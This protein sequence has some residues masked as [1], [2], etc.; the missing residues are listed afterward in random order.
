VSIYQRP[1]DIQREGPALVL[2]GKQGAAAGSIE[3][4]SP[5]NYLAVRLKAGERWRYQ[6]P[7]GHTVLWTAVASGTVS[8]PNEL[9][10]GDMA[11]FF[12]QHELARAFVGLETGVGVDIDRETHTTIVAP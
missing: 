3:A 10:Q 1:E 8:V 5:I 4:P 7:E 2:L 6:P 11:A 9:R 12:V